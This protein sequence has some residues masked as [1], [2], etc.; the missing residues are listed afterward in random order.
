MKSFLAASAAVLTLI[1]TASADWVIEA[2]IESP[3]INSASI[4]KVKGDKIR[5]DITAGPAGPLSSIMDS[6]TGDSITLLHAQKMAM[7]S[8][9]DQ[10][11]QALE[12]A[13]KSLGGGG[14]APA[15]NVKPKPTGQKEKIGD[16]ECEIW[17]WTGG[18]TSI[19]YWIASNHPQA[20]MLKDLEKKMR[21]S[22]L[23]AGQVGPEP[24]D[25]PGVP[26]KTE[27]D[28]NG[29]KM[30][31]SIVSVKEADVDAKDFEA[32]ADYQVMAMPSFPAAPPA[33]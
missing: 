13:K 3:Q 19:K 16:F 24:G 23:G 29:S 25:I 12:M 9:G 6:T 20:A 31:M 4:M 1:A 26:L 18:N 15:T 5:A 8:T 32:P 2:K 28:N 30:T 21:K 22:A 14:A 11:K 33:K 27:S 7:K 17:T 10:V